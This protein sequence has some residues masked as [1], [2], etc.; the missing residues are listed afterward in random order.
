MKVKNLLLMALAAFSLTFAACEPTEEPVVDDGTEE[1]PGGDDTTPDDPDDGTEEPVEVVFTV[2][3]T[4]ITT[5]SA[6][7]SVTPSDA[8]VTYYFDL[9]EKSVFDKYGDASVLLEEVIAD[10]QGYESYGYS[11][12]DFLSQGADSYTYE[13]DT[14]LDPSTEYCVYVAGVDADG[15][16]TT[17]VTT[18]TFTTEAIVPSDNTF[19]VTETNGHIEITPTNDDPYVWSVFTTESL[20]DLSDE[21]L[22]DGV[23]YTLGEDLPYYITTGAYAVDMT[24][25]EE[26]VS[27]TVL[28]FGYDGGA[29]TGL[30]KY[31]FTYEAA[32]AADEVAL[33]MTGGYFTFYG[34]EDDPNVN[35]WNLDFYNDT[36]NLWVNFNSELS[37]G[38]N[39]SGEYTIDPGNGTAAGTAAADLS[40]YYD[41]V[42]DYEITFVEG[43]FKISVDGENYTISIN[44][45]GS[46][47]KTYTCEYSGAL[48]LYDVTEYSS[49]APSR[50]VLNAGLIKAAKLRS[51]VKK[52]GV[53]EVGNTKIMKLSSVLR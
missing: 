16:I 47:G 33:T 26:G 27:Y 36:A 39:P 17:D 38:T 10:L 49:L 30:T 18:E 46:D 22:I 25:L 2:S 50:K 28:V 35:N 20:G 21:E 19:T 14:A 52:L 6:T 13:G 11:L 5:N 48:D 34:D 24:N 15:T 12:T 8:T 23:L 45:K 42:Q 40:G 44:V 41:Y 29:T 43:S 37:A 1:V 4:D 53:S 31:E 51:V 7:V 3:V 9:I 32:A